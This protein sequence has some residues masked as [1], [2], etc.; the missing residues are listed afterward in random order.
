MFVQFSRHKVLAEKVKSLAPC[1][2]SKVRSAARLDEQFVGN[3][4]KVGDSVKWL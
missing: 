4:I 1:R 3:G 2:V